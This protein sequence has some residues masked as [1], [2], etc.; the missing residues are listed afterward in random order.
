MAVEARHGMAI[1][2]DISVFGVGFG[3]VPDAVE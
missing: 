1:E 2:S 3:N